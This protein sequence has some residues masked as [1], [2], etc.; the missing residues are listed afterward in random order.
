[1]KMCT[2][3]SY[4]TPIGQ[5][6]GSPHTSHMGNR[7]AVPNYSPYPETLQDFYS[8]LRNQDSGTGGDGNGRQMQFF[9]PNFLSLTMPGICTGK[10]MA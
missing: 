8:L 6:W 5:D 7:E 2:V 3:M 1:M 4:H 9:S 10:N